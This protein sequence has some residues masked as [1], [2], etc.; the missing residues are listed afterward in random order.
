MAHR[1]GLHHLAELIGR[2]GILAGRDVEAAFGSHLGERRKILR[3]PDRLLQKQRRGV[4]AGMRECDGGL[5][6]ERQFMSTISGT[7]CRSPAARRILQASW[8]R[9]A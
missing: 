9:A 1:A 3:W 5:A 8:F 2:A 7:C 6:I 4:P